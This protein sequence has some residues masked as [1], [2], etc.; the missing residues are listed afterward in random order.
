V[1]LLELVKKMSIE[2]KLAQMT[3]LSGIFFTSGKDTEITG[4]MKE[5]GMSPEIINNAGSILGTTGAQTII[6]IQRSFLK[7][8]PYGIPLL[9]MADVIHGFRTIF[10]IPLAMSCSWEPEIIEESA[11]I[12][13]REASVSGISVTFSP[14]VDLVRDA[15]WGRVAESIGEDPYLA[16]LFAKAFVRGYQGGDLRNHTDRIAACVKHFAAYGAAEAGREYNTVEMGEPA[17]RQNYLPAYYGALEEGCQMVMS[18]F[19]TLNGVPVTCNK[20]LLKDI[21]RNEW[22]FKGPVITDWGAVSELIPHGVAEDGM[23]AAKK[24]I[25]AG[26]DIEMATTNFARYAESLIEAGELDEALI[27]QAVLRIL[28]LKD[29]LGLFENPYRGADPEKEKEVLLCSEHRN[30]ARR[31][32]AKSMVLL[33]NNGVLPLSRTVNK[34]AVI[35]PYTEPV[36]ILGCWRC[37]GKNEEAVPLSS[38]ILSK[39]TSNRVAFAKGCGI[40]EGDDKDIADAVAAAKNADVI[41]LALGEHYKMTGEAGSRAYITLPGRQNE[42]AD[43]IFSLGK[44]TVIVLFNGRPLEIRNLA[45]KASAIL[46]VWFPGTEGGSAIADILF[47]DESPSGRLTMSFPYTVGQVPI[48]YNCLNTGRPKGDDSNTARNTSRYLDIPN[49]PLYPF[50]YGLTYTTFEYSNANLNSNILVRGSKIVLTV[51][52]T[53]TGERAGEET[54]QLYLRDISAVISRPVLELKDYKKVCIEPGESQDVS[55]DI[56]ESMLEYYNTNKIKMS[57][58]GK[59]TA[60][61]GANSRDLIALNF[62]YKYNAK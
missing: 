43:A 8:N 34:L 19:N 10:P 26:I 58:Q 29:N 54:V 27:D 33:K 18:A 48:Y 46:E 16:S 55:F 14:M 20:W 13:A 7:N 59:F 9:F 50:G 61:V 28:E 52:V 22:G 5:M 24:A 51:T 23:E 32:A 56:N 44:P 11:A 3:Q 47:G 39:L 42:L 15:R 1:N 37:L 35:G 57:E 49:A 40:S 45:E 12:S 30:A 62:E 17:L 21:L 60:F 41:V 36:N 38:G 2:E 25:E 53:N 6:D 4:P 31:I